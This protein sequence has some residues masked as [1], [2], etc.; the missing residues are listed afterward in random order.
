M[1]LRTSGSLMVIER[2]P[3]AGLIVNL[4]RVEVMDSDVTR[5]VRDLAAGARRMGVETVVCS[6]PPV[7][8]D[9]MVEMGLELGELRTSLD[10]DSAVR[11]LRRST[12]RGASE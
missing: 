12:Q 9:T 7:V 10:I 4:A 5:C 1:N 2:D 3:P 11:L 6:V 8:A